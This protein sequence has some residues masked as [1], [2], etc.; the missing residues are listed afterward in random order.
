MYLNMLDE[1]LSI[2]LLKIIYLT[3][4][5][6]LKITLISYISCRDHKTL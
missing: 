2:I 5:I 4:K 6:N 1:Q 3:N